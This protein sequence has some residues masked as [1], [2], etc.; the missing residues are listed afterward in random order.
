MMRRK[1]RPGIHK[2]GDSEV[3]G[4]PSP[5]G[6]RG[7]IPAAMTRLVG[8]GSTVTSVV[9]L[10]QTSGVRWVT[11]L[12]PGGIGKTRV[13]MAVAQDLADADVRVCW[14][15][16]A[17][18][19]VVS[20]VLPAIADAVGLQESTGSDDALLDR[21][22][23]LLR[24]GRWV[25]VLDNLEHVIE[26]APRITGILRAAP[27]V[28]VLATS[29][30]YVRIEG[31]H[32]FPVAPLALPPA[33]DVGATH[34]LTAPAVALFL[35][36]AIALAPE[37]DPAPDQL[38]AIVAMC[39]ALDGLPLA[40]ELAAARMDRWEPARIL[41]DLDQRLA[42][43]VDGPIDVPDRHRSLRAAF[44]WSHDLLSPTARVVFRR[45]SVVAGDVGE[46]AV[47]AMTSLDDEPPPEIVLAA[48]VEL[49]RASLIVRVPAPGQT[50]WSM[51]ATLREYAFD[52][53]RAADEVDAVMD[54]LAVWAQTRADIAAAAAFLP[55]QDEVLGNLERERSHLMAVFS[56]LDARGEIERFVDLAGQLRTFWFLRAHYD[57][58]SRM[59]NRAL[60]FGQTCIP[61]ARGRVHQGIAMLA[62]AQTD[63][64]RAISAFDAAHALLIEARA[65][66]REIA[67]GLLGRS[68][69]AFQA[70]QVD[71][72]KADQQAALDVI[73]DDDPL[74]RNAMGIAA[75]AN[76]AYLKGLEGKTEDAMAL[77]DEAQRQQEE[78]GV[79]WYL[80]ILWRQRGVIAERNGD[81]DAARTAYCSSLAV[82][83]ERHRDLRLVAEAI[84][85][86]VS[87]AI[88]QRDFRHAARLLGA[89]ATLRVRI[90]GSRVAP[91]DRQQFFR[92]AILDEIDAATFDHVMA[93]G[94]ALSESDL[95]LVASG[96]QG[97]P[98]LDEARTD[99]VTSDPDPS[100]ILTEMQLRILRL[101]VDGLT[102]R[103]IGG[104][105]I[106][107]RTGRPLSEHTVE[108]H[109]SDL[110]RRLGCS[111]RAQA[112]A[113]AVRNGIV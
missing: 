76:L 58:G 69:A 63:H 39:T 21:V 26:I 100:Q 8:R 52:H 112:T 40:I 51:L 80:A 75:I 87:V 67:I 10:I 74:F 24:V 60:A 28:S 110:L 79:T 85:G 81:F 3:T 16:L 45:L 90:G 78:T 49:E 101:M 97:H 1:R 38:G 73:S 86:L 35:Q 34:L 36:S 9:A 41:E 108:R 50:R 43:L 14:V 31:E 61:L 5:R 71:Q 15:D 56:W 12:G 104:Q 32:R 48:M 6:V 19:R 27:G 30:H 84:L 62:L 99:V 22:I 44:D 4:S 2:V 47:L 98:P 65:D 111:S 96:E 54:R 82:S 68:T 23:D 95:L 105:L 113:W 59:L 42:V 18:L 70:G 102:N 94:A 93:E 92:S 55:H 66:S 29:R 33:A 37:F 57:E 88:K 20:E 89:E 83:I 17:T 106:S 109:V 25:I 13:A 72:A 53:L 11:L 107:D 91:T 77:F 64:A 7:Q 103:E 46:D